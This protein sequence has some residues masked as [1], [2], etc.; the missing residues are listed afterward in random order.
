MSCEF[1]FRF[2]MVGFALF[3]WSAIV[4]GLGYFLGGLKDEG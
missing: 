2:V 4:F 3:A 1:L